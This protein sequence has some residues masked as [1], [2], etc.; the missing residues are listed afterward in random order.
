MLFLTTCIKHG[1]IPSQNVTLSSEA[2]SFDQL[3]MLAKLEDAK[4]KLT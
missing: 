2:L 4:K 3:D 1:M